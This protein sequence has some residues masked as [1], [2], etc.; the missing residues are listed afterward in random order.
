[1]IIGK[2]EPVLD[3]LHRFKTTVTIPEGTIVDGNKCIVF[4]DYLPILIRKN[5]R[6]HKE[7]D[8]WKDR[9]IYPN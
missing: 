6:E 7:D 4:P 3:H 9:L 5:I 2:E 1:M 8:S